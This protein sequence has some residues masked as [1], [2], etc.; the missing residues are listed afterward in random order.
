MPI[1]VVSKLNLS[2]VEG[3]ILRT[4]TGPPPLLKLKSCSRFGKMHLHLFVHGI[5]AKL[6]TVVHQNWA[7]F[8][9]P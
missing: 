8:V 9:I 6:L 2:E 5:K 4:W 7:R 3:N 1:T